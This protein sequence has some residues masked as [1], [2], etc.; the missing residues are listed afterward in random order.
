MISYTVLGKIIRS[1]LFCA[2]PSPY[3][4]FSL[5]TNF[6]FVLFT[7]RRKKPGLQNFHRFGTVFML[8][9]LVLASNYQASRKMS[10]SYRTIGFVDM[11]PSCS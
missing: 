1:H 2:A 4:L 7:L 3:Q 10:N 5:L 6:G 8:R 9:T 11:L